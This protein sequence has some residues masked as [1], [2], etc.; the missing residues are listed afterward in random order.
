MKKFIIL[1]LLFLSLIAFSKRNIDK[2]IT[3]NYTGISNIT[4]KNKSIDVK[5]IGSED[6]NT[7]IKAEI[8]GSILRGNDIDIKFNKNGNTL[9]IEVIYPS[10][11]ISMNFSKAEIYIV[12]NKSTDFLIDSSSGDIYIEGFDNNFSSI[13][14]SSGEITVDNIKCSKTVTIKAS[15]GD[16]EAH[17][18]QSSLNVKASSGEITA[19]DISGVVMAK[20][21]SGDIE[22]KKCDHDVKI[23]T[24]SGNILAMNIN[25][26][27]SG[28]SSSGDH[29]Y[30]D[31]SGNIEARAS[32]G[33]VN[34]N[35]S[36]GYFKLNTSSGNI[37][38][39]S[40]S[41][42]INA[43]AGSGNINGK[44]ITLLKS[45]KFTTNSG[46]TRI[47]LNNSPQDLRFLLTSRSGDLHINDMEN[48]KNLTYGNGSIQIIGK[49][50]SGYQK[51]TSR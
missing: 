46:D 38:L 19:E 15:S 27:I 39:T 13:N 32:S 42:T 14:S 35:D 6:K 7:T 33:R 23:K 28:Y 37:D 25:G 24:S 41:G 1:P 51:Y 34:I 31:I 3:K 12:T 22:I 16:I 10:R 50:G 21:S 47:S 4:C 26:N 43:E 49:S 2:K 44:D 8:K 5:L 11:S 17:N 20:A 30:T 36:N 48:E 40:L 9:D 18:I 29:R 45:N